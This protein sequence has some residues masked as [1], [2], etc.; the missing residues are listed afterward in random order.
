MSERPELLFVH[1]AWHGAWCWDAVRS[2]LAAR[3]WQT[4]AIDL[5]T[6][7]AESGKAA[8]GIQD[9]ADA[10]TA[11]L[12]AM[13]DDVVVIAHSYGG[14]PIS[15]SEASLRARH[16]IYV[17]AFMPD[18]GE[19]LLDARAGVPPEWWTVADGLV[20]PGIPT[21]GPREL[22]F[23]D[24]DPDEAATYIHRLASQSLRACTDKTTRAA[25]RH[26]PSTFVVTLDDA[27]SDPARQRRTAQKATRSVGLP[28][29]HSPFVSAPELLAAVIEEAATTS[30]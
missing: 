17:S 10:V 12:D 20:T 1:G 30:V 21:R 3:G 24:V 14:V 4:H 29:G 8:K 28:T 15:Q 2:V 5:P 19:S 11:A 7:H 25:W 23:N 18:A 27:I 13:G 6:V 26:V 9:D 16:L 22:F